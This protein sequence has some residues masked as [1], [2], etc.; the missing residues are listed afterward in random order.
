MCVYVY[1]C[2]CIHIYSFNIVATGNKGYLMRLEIK[3]IL[4]YLNFYLA[5][6]MIPTLIDNLLHVFSIAS[7]M[8][9]G[10]QFELRK[11]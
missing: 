10:H 3:V 1:I 9:V 7:S 5:F 6:S 4:S 11:I 2:K 8:K